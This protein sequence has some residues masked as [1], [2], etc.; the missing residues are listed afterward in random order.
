MAAEQNFDDTI[1]LYS[2]SCDEAPVYSDDPGVKRVGKVNVTFSI[3]DVLAAEKSWSSEHG[4]YVYRLKY[5]LSMKYREGQ[6][7]FITLV[8]DKE[9]GT[10][11]FA[12]A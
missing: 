5:V 12:F 10:A 1:D 2:C 3:T 4:C 6:L 7:I 8:E 9:R 11:R